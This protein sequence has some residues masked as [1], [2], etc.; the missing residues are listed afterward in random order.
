MKTK[1]SE[2]EFYAWT[3]D[4]VLRMYHNVVVQCY[5]NIESIHSSIWAKIFKKLARR[6][7]DDQYAYMN[8]ANDGIDKRIKELETTYNVEVSRFNTLTGEWLS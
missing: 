3:W 6:K 8:W 7:L 1:N 5:R 4:P 2:K